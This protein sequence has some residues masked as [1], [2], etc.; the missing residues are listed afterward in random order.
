MWSGHNEFEKADDLDTLLGVELGQVDRAPTD[1]T[2]RVMGEMGYRPV[3]GAEWRRRHRSRIA[4]RGLVA[5]GVGVVLAVS[6]SVLH[7]T[8]GDVAP[9]VPLDAAIAADFDAV[10]SSVLD[11]FAQ[12]AP[13]P[14]ASEQGAAGID[15]DRRIDPLSAGRAAG[16]EAESLGRLD[17]VRRPSA[18]DAALARVFDGQSQS[19]PQSQPQSQN[20][21]Q[22]GASADRTVSTQSPRSWGPPID[23]VPSLRVGP[24]QFPS[25]RSIDPAAE[26]NGPPWLNGSSSPAPANG[27][28]TD[29]PSNELPDAAD[30]AT[31][32]PLTDA[33]SS[34]PATPSVPAVDTLTHQTRWMA[35]IV[36]S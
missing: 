4:W 22:A 17:R 10:R 8:R 29:R 30:R 18:V 12:L 20:Q 33:R 35:R 7:L 19:Q 24:S 14:S 15:A 25:G 36:A 6:G 5:A 21:N 3:T 23:F 26:V 31:L 28:V 9:E 13:D 27:D 2:A 32:G 1:L 16:D 11:S 34:S